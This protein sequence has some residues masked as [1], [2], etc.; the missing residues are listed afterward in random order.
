MI[1]FSC[2]KISTIS[3]HPSVLRNRDIILTGDELGMMEDALVAYSDLENVL[4]QVIPALVFSHHLFLNNHAL[5][6]VFNTLQP[7]C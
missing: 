7:R 3:L 4:F 5:K 1:Q 2:L 6:S